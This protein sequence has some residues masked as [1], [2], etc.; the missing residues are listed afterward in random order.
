[1]A[2][3]VMIKRRVPQGAKARVLIPLILRL[4]ALA[5]YQPGYISGETLR[6]MNEPEECVVISKWHSLE[7]WENW[8]ATAERRELQKK[9]DEVT[10]NKTEYDIY[11]TM[12]CES[13]C[14]IN[15]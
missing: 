11:E 13:D 1:M 8:L 5:T 10:G 7:H 14:D 3:E 6:N 2:V 9:I 12:I 15:R 4:R